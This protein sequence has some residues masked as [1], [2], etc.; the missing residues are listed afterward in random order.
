MKTS[1]LQNQIANLLPQVENKKILKAVHD[2]LAEEAMPHKLSQAQMDELDRRE[3]AYLKG[4]GKSYSW[5]EVQEMI[6]NRSKI[7]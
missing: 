7:K 2:I 5:E 4:E 6:L 3:E 1:L